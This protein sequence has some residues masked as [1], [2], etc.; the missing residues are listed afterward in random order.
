MGLAR[1]SVEA[2]L[3]LSRAA[4]GATFATEEEA[5]ANESAGAVAVVSIKGPLAQDADE[6]CGWYDGYGGENGI[7]ARVIAAL[8][9]SNVGAVVLRFDSPGGTSAGIEESIRRMVAAREASGK[10]VLAIVDEQ[11]CSAAYWIAATVAADGIYAPR[12]SE[13]GSIGSWQLHIDESKALEMDGYKPTFVADPPDKVAGNSFEPLS[14]VGLA[15]MDRDT[16]ACTAR[17]M[18]S[19]MAA[20]GVSEEMLRKTLAGD[21]IEGEAALAAGLIDGIGSV[22]DVIALAASL[23]QSKPT[24]ASAPTNSDGETTMPFS[25][26]VRNA[27]GLGADA[28]DAAVESAA[29]SLAGLGRHCMTLVSASSPDEARGAIEAKIRD[30]AEVPALRQREASANA[31]AEESTRY[32]ILEQG[33]RDGKINPSLAFKFS[34][35][36]NGEKVRSLSAWASAPHKNEAGEDVGQ[37][38]GQLKAY[39]ASAAP[40]SFMP[41]QAKAPKE[42]EEAASSV[43]DEQKAANIGVSVEAYRAG[44]KLTESAAR[45]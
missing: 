44:R 30:A 1:V 42:R 38:L 7:T 11:C 31:A 4:W 21:V 9:D 25:A 26:R 2:P 13:T 45:Q 24:G 19:V 37:S 40:G 10:P 8:T 16:K 5:P 35:G 28:S 18:A 15:R 22:E 23:A 36:A 29:I 33:V 12:R 27:M 6:L 17:F 3:C 41:S 32:S 43:D 39:I 34:E 20:R 14:E